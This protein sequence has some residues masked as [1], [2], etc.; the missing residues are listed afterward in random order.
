MV[1]T[2]RA[3]QCLAELDVLLSLEKG[4]YEIHVALDAE[5]EQLTLSVASALN[6][7]DPDHEEQSVNDL[8]THHHHPLLRAV[9]GSGS[10]TT[11][12][13][14]H[15]DAS[16]HRV[17]AASKLEFVTFL[18]LLSSAGEFHVF[19]HPL[20]FQCP[21][22]GVSHQGGQ[23]RLAQVDTNN[24]PP[25]VMIIAGSDS[26]GGAGIQADLKACTNLGVYSSSA[27][28]A[29][30]VQNTQGVH[31]IH[32]IPV[33]DIADQIT[34]VLDDIGADVVKVRKVNIRT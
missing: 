25:R 31:G 13:K 15:Y 8:K 26:G 3:P 34:C 10:A 27:V 20:A 24:T 16:M 6:E 14:E 33:N 9:V 5:R 19:A 1:H 7:E 4:E 18:R 12:L 30:T 21:E 2:N 17:T 29:V 23:Y 22:K 32:A 28:T 11:T